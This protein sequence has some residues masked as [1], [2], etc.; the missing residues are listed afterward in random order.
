[1]L[2]NDVKYYVVRDFHE[3]GYILNNVFYEYAFGIELP[4]NIENGQIIHSTGTDMVNFKP[5]VIA[6]I[7][8]NTVVNNQG[9]VFQLQTEK[10]Q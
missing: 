5:E 4:I 8:G 10:P 2:E 9:A 7:N 3:Y 1:M 6:T